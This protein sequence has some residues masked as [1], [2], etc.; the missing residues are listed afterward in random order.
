MD[1]HLAG[2]WPTHL[3]LQCPPSDAVAPAGPIYRLVESFPA[4]PDDMKS[5]LELGTFKGKDQCLRA[6]LSCSTGPEYLEDLRGSVPRLKN[7]KIAVA[8]LDHTHGVIKQTGHEDHYSLWLLGAVLVNA[9]ALF[10]AHS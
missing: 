3:P 9:H 4:T 7:Q 10:G 6:S 5:A 8:L 2:H 1:G